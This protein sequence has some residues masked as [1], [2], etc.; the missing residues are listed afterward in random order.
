MKSKPFH[1]QPVPAQVH[2]SSEE[3]ARH[4]RLKTYDYA[5]KQAISE[6]QL[7]KYDKIAYELDDI[8][9]RAK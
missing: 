2:D 7:E 1:G 9:H 4:D 5:T 6:E 8:I 3:Q